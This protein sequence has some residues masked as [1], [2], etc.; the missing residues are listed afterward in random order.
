MKILCSQCNATY[1]LKDKIL[2]RAKKM[3]V[4]CKKCGGRI[5]LDRDST[6]P[7]KKTDGAHCPPI[8]PTSQASP[9]QPVEVLNVYPQL[10]GLSPRTFA[11]TEIFI[12]G[13]RGGFKT[14]RNTFKVK[15]LGAVKDVVENMLRKDEVVMRIAAGTAYFPVEILFGNGWLT[16]LYNR[17]ALIATNQRLLMINTNHRMTKPAH[18]VYQMPYSNIKKVERG[19]F[20]RNIVLVPKKGKRKIFTSMT[21][22]LSAEMSKFIRNHIDSAIPVGTPQSMLTDLCPACFAALEKS[23]SNCT[24]CAAEFKTPKKAMLKSLVLPGWGDIYLGHRLLGFIE[25][26][27]SLFIWLIFFGLLMSGLAQDLIIG[28]LLLVFYNGADS[29]LTYYMARK[30]YILEK[31]QSMQPAAGRLVQ[32]SA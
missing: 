24:S 13:K 11:L 28:L 22:Y 5:V 20:R 9:A 26:L 6:Q 4:T 17:Y 12:P 16:M 19:L 31:K 32:S 25:V 1:T 23:L 7:A 30:G 2:P 27:G 18:Y 8:S 29:M 3:A 10:A 15:I 14:S 21:A